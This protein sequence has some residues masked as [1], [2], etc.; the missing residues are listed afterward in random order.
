MIQTVTM[1]PITEASAASASETER[2][3]LWRVLLHDDDFHTYEYVIEMLGALFGMDF[4]RA[5]R[6]AREVDEVGVT[7]VARLPREEAERKVYEIMRYGG[8]PRMR[9]ALSMRAS[10]E[11][12]ET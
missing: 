2:A 10:T 11:P 5:L 9:T 6:H 8:D 1:D 7:E 4:Q 3:P 12:C